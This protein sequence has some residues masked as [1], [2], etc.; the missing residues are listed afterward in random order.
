MI[1]NTMSYEEF[2]KKLNL[3]NEKIYYSLINGG[4]HAILVGDVRKRENTIV[5]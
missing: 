2:I 3:V 1:S 5:L 4:R